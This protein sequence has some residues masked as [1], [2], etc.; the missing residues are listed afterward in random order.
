MWNGEWN[1]SFGKL[2][3]E[4]DGINVS[5]DYVNEGIIEGTID[6]SGSVLE[7]SFTN[8]THSKKGFFRFSLKSNSKFRGKWKWDNSTKWK[9]GWNG[10][11]SNQAHDEL[12]RFVLHTTHDISSDNLKKHVD[13]ALG[14][15]SLEYIPDL[16]KTD[17]S[18]W[19]YH[20]ES[21]ERKPYYFD[22]KKRKFIKNTPHYFVN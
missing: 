18:F 12:I 16:L 20:N 2:V 4:T 3:L 22:Y 13:I 1:T 14:K 8:L 10:S 7:G 9:G 15:A 17:S 6:S 5:G 11:K 19:K 21:K